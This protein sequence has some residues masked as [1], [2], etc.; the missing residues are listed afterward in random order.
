MYI[1]EVDGWKRFGGR[2]ADQA[3][4]ICEREQPAGLVSFGHC[5]VVQQVAD[6]TQDAQG[7]GSFETPNQIVLAVGQVCA[8]GADEFSGVTHDLG[9]GPG[10]IGRVSVKHPCGVNVGLRGG[11]GGE[12]G[13]VGRLA[14]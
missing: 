9:H 8:V 7:V 1:V 5:V 12:C 13:V 3:K 10:E 14:G 2:L 11:P 6:S 4:V